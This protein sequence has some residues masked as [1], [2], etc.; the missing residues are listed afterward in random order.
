MNTKVTQ[1]LRS[2]NE[3]CMSKEKVERYLIMINAEF[4]NFIW[5]KD[6]RETL[7]GRPYK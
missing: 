1:V 6:I 3:N 2:F 5:D 7:H 4:D